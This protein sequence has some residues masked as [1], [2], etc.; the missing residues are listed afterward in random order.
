[1]ATDLQSLLHPRSCALVLQEV[2]N[3]VV[4]DEAVFPE[5]AAVAQRVRLV[6]HCVDLARAARAA[7]VTVFHCTAA[8]RADRI[9]ANTNARLFHAAQKTGSLLAPGS[10]GVEV[11]ARIG[12]ENGDVVLPRHHG[13]GPLTGTQ[14]DP[15]LR[16][17]GVTTIVAAGVS[18]NVGMLDLVIT[19]VNLGYQVVLPTDAVAGVPFEY[20]QEVIANTMSVLATLTTTRAVTA[21]WAVSP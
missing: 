20:G 17:A 15:M 13:L 3:G 1:M 18:L 9:G 14:L 12:V 16:N 19:A 8:T 7:N 6:D 4:G 10:S 5:L 21:A 11:P 2:Q